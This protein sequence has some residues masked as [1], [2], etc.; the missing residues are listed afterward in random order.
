M[1]K[2][3]LP[4]I[5]GKFGD[6]MY[7]IVT[8]KLSDVAEKE[9]ISTVSEIAELYPKNINYVLQR[10][11][12]TKRINKISE[13]LQKQDERFLSSLIV[14][15]HKGNPTFSEIRIED[16]FKIGNKVED[17]NLQYAKGRI[18]FLTL[19]GDEKIFALDGQHRLKGIREA[20]KNP[21]VKDDDI[22]VTIVVHDS[23]KKERTRRLFTVLNRY[24]EKPKKAEWIVM[25]EDDA[26]AILTRRLLLTND[27][28]K[29]DNSISKTR[30]FAIP[31]SDL[32]S[33]S[34]LVCLYDI[35]KEIIEYKKLYP[36]ST[37]I[38]RP[39]NKKIDEL[40]ESHILNFWNYIL[41]TF[42]EIIAFVNGTLND[43]E[44]VRN[45][46]NGGSLLLRPEGQLTIAEL[47]MY[48]SQKGVKE[49]SSFKKKLPKIDFN[50]TN[51]IWR[52]L[53]WNGEKMN[54][55]NRP[56]KKRVLLYLLGEKI[57]L[58]ILKKDIQKVYDDY[59]DKF[60]AKLLYQIK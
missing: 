20:G 36:K 30:G 8:M 48:F 43:E 40:Y 7:F 10:E 57:D 12:D 4:S 34:T 44:F 6:W 31:A 17:E 38:E 47:Y 21:K 45:K 13:Y 41:S 46:K 35:S 27:F 54:H 39:S 55:K 18:G 29:K 32:K 15:I 49:L 53:Y 60:D 25:E 9:R 50:L 11:L 58:T 22:M 24:A 52:Y 59:N 56:L 51:P 28:F 1:N 19:T 2:I 5:K 26:A 23:N 16:A 33:F 37:V 3:I 42:P 14:A